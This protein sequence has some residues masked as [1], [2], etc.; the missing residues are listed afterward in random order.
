MN[1]KENTITRSYYNGLHRGN[2]DSVYKTKS[3][4]T[5]M[6]KFYCIFLIYLLN[7]FFKN[8]VIKESLLLFH[9]IIIKGNI[10]NKREEMKAASH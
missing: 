1:V 6:D 2:T 5:G 10:G 4:I 7:T 3:H 9:F 8:N